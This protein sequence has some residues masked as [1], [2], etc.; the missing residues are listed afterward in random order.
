MRYEV[1]EDG[2]ASVVCVKGVLVVCV[3]VWERLM[4]MFFFFFKQKTAYEV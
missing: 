1:C 3:V 2:C 4:F